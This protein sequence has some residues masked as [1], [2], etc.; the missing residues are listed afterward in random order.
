MSEEKMFVDPS[1]QALLH[2]GIMHETPLDTIV[3]VFTAK[4]A[5]YKE[6]WCKRGKLA[7]VAS[8]ARKVDRLEKVKANTE[9]MFD[10][11]LDLV[12]YLALYNIM[13]EREKGLQASTVERFVY[14]LQKVDDSF[15]N[16]DVSFNSV[17]INRIK[18][19]YDVFLRASAAS[20]VRAH[21]ERYG[22]TLTARHDISAFI[23]ESAVNDL[24]ELAYSYSQETLK[25]AWVL[26]YREHNNIKALCK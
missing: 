9:S 15:D 5:S 18:F 25:M 6:S 21:P 8:M 17:L 14:W 1:K 2:L 4:N 23:S 7:F 22:V 19:N 26:Y 12:A 13:L 20:E 24:E 10:T 16:F 11:T 3:R